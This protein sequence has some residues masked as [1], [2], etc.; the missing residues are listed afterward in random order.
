[1][2]FPTRLDY[3]TKFILAALHKAVEPYRKEVDNLSAAT[4]HTCHDHCQ[5][6]ECVQRRHIQQLQAENEAL[7]AQ[8]QEER[9]AFIKLNNDV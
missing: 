1:M 5:R 3:A 9:I 6:I 2:P 7:K 4:I 8:V